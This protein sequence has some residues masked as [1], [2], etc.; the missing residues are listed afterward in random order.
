MAAD[1][2]LAESA[3]VHDRLL[4][5]MRRRIDGAGNGHIEGLV[6]TSAGLSRENWVFDFVDD[7]GV[8]HELILRRDPPAAVLNTERAVELAILR[9]LERV[10]FAAPR[11][12]WA[13]LEGEHFGRPSMIMERARGECDYMILNG[14]R[15]LEQRVALAGK[16]CQLL[17]DVHAVDLD[18]SGLRDVLGDPGPNAAAY[19]VAEWLDTLHREVSAPYPELEMAAMWLTRRAPT[20][21]RSV[22]VHADFKPGNALV[23]D[24]EISILL[25]WE[26]AHVGDPVE[27]L[28]W[29]TQ[30]LRANE[31]QID[32]AWTASDLVG[33]YE[34]I[35]GTRVDAESLRWWQ[36]FS[37]FKSAVIQ[38]TG[39]EAYVTGKSD[40]LFREPAP[41][42]RELVQAMA[43]DLA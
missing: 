7:L 18:A 43:A 42:L 24:D 38:L 39:L 32:G 40:R 4:D 14:S 25:D 17:A 29:V 21:S 26:I 2:K 16:F 30:P 41:F 10:N 1:I 13:D 37:S 8:V 28:G 12:L 19:A 11:V 22:L 5:Y 31:H 36:L 23:E 27:D 6:R 9:G 3:E 15:P 33:R 35:T 34:D 20:A